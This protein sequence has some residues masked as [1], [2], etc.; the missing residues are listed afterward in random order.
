MT[1]RVYR[2]AG[3]YGDTLLDAFHYNAYN[4]TKSQ[5]STYVYEPT[6][7]AIDFTCQN[8]LAKGIGKQ[9][10]GEG[11]SKHGI[12]YPPVADNAQKYYDL[13]IKPEVTQNLLV[14]TA[15]NSTEAADTEEA[16]TTEAYDIVHTALNYDEEKKEVLIKGHHLVANKTSVGTGNGTA[17]GTTGGFT[18]PYFHL[19]ERTPEGKNSENENC[20]NNDFCAPIPFTVT[21]HAW[22]VRKPMY[23]AEETTGAWEGISL[24]FTVNKVK[25]QVNGE[26]THFYGTPTTDEL[27]DPAN[28]THTL[29][30]EYWLRGLTGV[31]KE[32]ATATF[33][34]PG[35]IK[36]G[37]FQADNAAKWDYSFK[38]DFFMTTYGNKDYNY[39]ANPYY[40]EA[41]TYN[42]YL[43]LTANIPYVVR[44]PGYHY[45]EFD[46]SSKFYNEYTQGLGIENPAQTVTFH[47]YGREYEPKDE[48]IVE[49]GAIEIP[50]T[51]ST[52]T[53]GV[54][55]YSHMGT[56]KAQK[57]ANGTIYGM[58]DKGTAFSDKFAETS[59]FATVMPFR[60]YLT[61]AATTSQARS[62]A[63]PS[64]IRIADTTGI[65]K[66]E[67][68]V[69]ITD[70]DAP[71]GNYLIVQPIGGR[72][73]RIEST[74]ATQL[75]VFSTTGLLYRILDVQPGTATYSG[76]YPSI[77][78]FGNKKVIVR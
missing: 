36:D 38:N 52:G 60:T 56:F 75:Q 44:F 53:L 43:A 30:H 49:K 68:D 70:D 76:F 64:V 59:P 47:A 45:Y 55:G 57:V 23:Y 54:D 77:Y 48:E 65:E 28:N 69:K 9:G 63:A 32:K 35:S 51:A 7:T 31:N 18:T 3:Y 10:I 72:R 46:L 8:D 41:H 24:P 34:R 37:L 67:P 27:A 11:I 16:N 21:K 58:N 19:V 33:Q 22:Y 4:S 6:T 12:F 66:I 14:Y 74:Y 20:S 50:I 71:S 25:A 29:H 78:I 5:W 17:D 40:K 62:S 15:A 26:I 13:M 61:P 42:A 39:K 1:N 2:T 73:I